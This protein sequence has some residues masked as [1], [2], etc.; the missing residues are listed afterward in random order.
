MDYKL[1][2]NQF[3]VNTF[4]EASNSY[5]Y[6]KNQSINE[7]LKAATY[8]TL[9]AWGFNPDNP[10]ALDRQVFSMRKNGQ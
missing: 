8:L 3:K 10:P 6:W 7:R 5:E 1:D 4:A 9:K 2:R